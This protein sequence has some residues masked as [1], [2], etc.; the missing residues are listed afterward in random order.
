MG[1]AGA[2][3]II[4]EHKRGMD[5]NICACQFAD[6]LQRICDLLDDEKEAQAKAV[7]PHIASKAT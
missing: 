6:L 4:T 5:G 1:G 2:V 3:N 7:Y